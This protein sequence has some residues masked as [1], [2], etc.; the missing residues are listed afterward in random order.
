M[1]PVMDELGRLA[2]RFWPT[3]WSL[4][5][6]R[7]AVGRAAWRARLELPGGRVMLEVTGRTAAVARSGI[8]DCLRRLDAER[9]V[10]APIRHVDRR[11]AGRRPAA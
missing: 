3:R 7:L 9:A 5:V 2:D 10:R 1:L 8:V 11:A 4:R 6:D